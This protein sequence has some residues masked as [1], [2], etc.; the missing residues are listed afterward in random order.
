MSAS[1]V[2]VVLSQV[3]DSSDSLATMMSS[4]SPRLASLAGAVA[5]GVGSSVT[6]VVT[7]VVSSSSTRTHAV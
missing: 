4:M 3:A 2:E 1:K 5:V 6:V 7:V